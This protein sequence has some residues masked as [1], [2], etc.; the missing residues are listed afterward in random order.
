MY[1]YQYKLH[2]P[3]NKIMENR[4]ENYVHFANTT[5]NAGLFG[6]GAEHQEKCVTKLIAKTFFSLE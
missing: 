5:C 4:C 3:H 2:W 6:F 1:L